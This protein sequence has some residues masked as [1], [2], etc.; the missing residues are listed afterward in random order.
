[1]LGGQRMSG[2]PPRV[3]VLGMHRSGTSAAT[4]VLNL[5][6]SPVAVDLYE[7]KHNPAGYWESAGLIDVNDRLLAA[8]GATWQRPRLPAMW[9]WSS[10]V[11]AL[12][13]E[14][15]QVFARAHPMASW[16]WKDPRTC[17][18][19]PI[20]RRLLGNVQVLLV[21]RDP[22]S[23]AASLAQRQRW[24]LGP[25][26]ALWE[27]YL[28]SAI[29]A[30]QGLPLVCVRCEDLVE[31]PQPTVRWLQASFADLGVEL[32]GDPEVAAASIKANLQ[33]YGGQTARL[34]R[35]QRALHLAADAMVGVHRAFDPPDLGRET[36]L[37]RFAGERRLD[38]L[39]LTG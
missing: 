1:M 30:A 29:A 4:R 21:L 25:A 39:R 10:S 9:E 17:L 2:S 23:V 12:E 8:A 27:R 28:R 32:S 5:L 34:S 14:A 6:G 31:D 36:R 22:A 20:W 7:G 13:G 38:A 24:P 16:V 11:R 26:I 3:V 19:F 18:T 33:H 37:L 15:K 35:R